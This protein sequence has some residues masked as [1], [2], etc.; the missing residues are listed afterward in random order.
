MGNTVGK[1]F[2]TLSILVGMSACSHNGDRALRISRVERILGLHYPYS[3]DVLSEFGDTGE[4]YELP[5]VPEGYVID[6]LTWAVPGGELGD[7]ST[8]VE[9]A[10]DS[11][12]RYIPAGTA[13]EPRYL[14]LGAR[15]ST[16]SG[17]RKLEIGSDE[18]A[19]VLDVLEVYCQDH[20]PDG[21]RNDGSYVLDEPETFLIDL[22]KL[23]RN[24]TDEQRN[25]GLLLPTLRFLQRQAAERAQSARSGA[26]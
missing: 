23:W 18:E 16:D 3:V 11:G 7:S 24:W 15:R 12:N 10:F 17:A 4:I 22:Q 20:L 26:G 25:A 19:G 1:V 8:V 14:Y 13:P 9:F 2:L 21:L 5:P 6:E